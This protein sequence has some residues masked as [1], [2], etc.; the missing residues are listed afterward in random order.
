M[1]NS[2]GTNTGA[3]QALSISRNGT[4]VVWNLDSDSDRHSNSQITNPSAVQTG[5]F[6]TA[7]LRGDVEFHSSVNISICVRGFCTVSRRLVKYFVE[8]ISTKTKRQTWISYPINLEV[9]YLRFK[10]SALGKVERV[11]LAARAQ[12]LELRVC[13]GLRRTNS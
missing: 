10:G 2:K 3:V 8:T 4:L 9:Q 1:S 13:G 6:D 12:E 7:Y 5:D 11:A